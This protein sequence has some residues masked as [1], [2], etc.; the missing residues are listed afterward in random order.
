MSSFEENLCQNTKFLLQTEQAAFCAAGLFLMP[1]S[2]RWREHGR[3][4]AQP[5]L[6]VCSANWS[7]AGHLLLLATLARQIVIVFKGLVRMSITNADFV[8]LENTILAV[9][10]ACDSGSCT[11]HIRGCLC[12]VLQNR[13]STQ[14]CRVMSVLCLLGAFLESFCFL[15]SQ[16]LKYNRLLAPALGKCGSARGAGRGRIW[17]QIPL[18]WDSSTS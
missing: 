4:T 6:S 15:G 14:S 13:Q 17:E 2:Q 5:R 12:F 7:F 1:L 18:E 11:F 16:A 9:S 3:D 8:L 10:Q